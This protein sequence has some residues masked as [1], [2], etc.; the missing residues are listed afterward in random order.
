MLQRSLFALALVFV[1]GQLSTADDGAQ[2][3]VKQEKKEKE[4]KSEASKKRAAKQKKLFEK[5]EK[6]M[7]GVKLVGQF[8]IVGRD[9]DKLPREEYTIKSVKKMPQGDLWLFNARIKY[10]GKDLTIPL[11]LQVKWAG[12][13]PVI[14]LTDVTIPGL[15]TFSC[16]V[17]IYNKKYSGTWTH[18]K[19]GGHMFGVLESADEG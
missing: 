18:G 12:D 5:F 3:E 8:T 17:V 1:L 4:A 14:S 7:T 13:T 19:V 10:G 15:G 2:K 9:S 6:T 11:P 16:R